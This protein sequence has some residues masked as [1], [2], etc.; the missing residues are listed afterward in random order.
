MH[1]DFCFFSCRNVMLLLAVWM[2]LFPFISCLF[3]QC[4]KSL[5][6]LFGKSYF[7]WLLQYSTIS[8]ATF[9]KHAIP[10]KIASIIPIFDSSGL[11]IVFQ[12]RNLLRFVFRRCFRSFRP[13]ESIKILGKTLLVFQSFYR[14]IIW[15]T[16]IDCF[17]IDHP[18]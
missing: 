16:L 13:Q 3:F 18:F 6:A 1:F 8:P 7:A 14:N 12:S 2:S 4:I 11:R 9:D 15:T 10:S 17:N 5:L